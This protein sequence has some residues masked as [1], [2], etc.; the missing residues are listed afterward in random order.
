MA[1]R[2][3]GGLRGGWD[4]AA[5]LAT[6]LTEQPP[7]ADAMASF[8][9]QQLTVKP[10][11]GVARR[12]AQ[13]VVAATKPKAPVKKAPVKKAGSVAKN[14]WLNAESGYDGSKWYGP[15]RKLFLPGGLLD[16]SE[17][18]DYL[19]GTLAGECVPLAPAAPRPRARI[20]PAAVVSVLVDGAAASAVPCTRPAEEARRRIAVAGREAIRRP[21]PGPEP[22]CS[23]PHPPPAHF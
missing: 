17:V 4:F 1:K 20:A 9:G 12:S 14:K 21:A 11:A 19:D 18:P 13:P 6:V 15:D 23:R 8:L 7:P 2:L 22:R 10:A 16:P 3:P 5:T